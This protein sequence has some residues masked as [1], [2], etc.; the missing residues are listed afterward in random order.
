MTKYELQL[1]NKEI[2]K[3]ANAQEVA[4]FYNE[5]SYQETI[6]TFNLETYKN[7]VRVLKSIN[8]DFSYKKTHSVTKGKPSKRSHESYINGG[9][10]SRETQKKNWENKSEEEKSEWSQKMRD[11]HGEEFKNLISNINIEYHKN[12]SQDVKDEINSKRSESCKQWWSSLSEE[13]KLN[14]VHNNIKHGA[15]WNHTK[16]KETLKEKYGV[17]N[18]SQLDS[19]K[20]QS[21]ESMIKTCLEKYG[22][23]W[24]CQLPQC[25]NSIGAKG[26]DTM[27]NLEF[28]KILDSNNI[29]YEREFVLDNF[30]YDFKV[31]NILIEINPSATHNSTWSPFGNHAGKEVDYHQ[32]K[33]NIALSHGYRCI[34]IFDWDDVLKIVELLKPRETIGARKCIVKE[35]SK[36]DAMNFINEYHLQSYARDKIRLGLYYNDKLISIMTFNKPRYNKNYQY[37]LIRYCSSMNVIGGANKLFKYFLDK[38]KPTSIVTYCDNAKFSGQVYED[39]KFKILRRNKPSR[40]WYNFRTGEHYTDSL[41][42]QQGFSRIINHVD[43]SKDTLETNNNYELM[44]EH[45]FVEVYDSGQTTYIFVV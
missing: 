11:S 33:T 10:K 44:V 39:L 27:P 23:M 9:K 16:I 32:R 40:H 17:E 41:I 7:L 31:D 18:I 12:L 38:Y 35:V 34:H 6:D 43:A 4:K 42:R 3:N 37:E 19:I 21:R 28:A 2:I 13:E 30:K 8:Y 24:N 14:I 29:K 5:H 36:S 15:G 26:A 1:H 25:N 20:K 45:G 22:V